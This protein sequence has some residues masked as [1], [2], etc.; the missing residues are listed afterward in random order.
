MLTLKNL[1]K[2]LLTLIKSFK[3]YI[4][5][6]N[7]MKIMCSKHYSQI[8]SSQYKAYNYFYITWLKQNFLFE[9]NAS[10]SILWKHKPLRRG[11]TNRPWMHQVILAE[12]VI[13]YRHA[14]PALCFSSPHPD[15]HET[16]CS[17]LESHLSSTCHTYLLNNQLEDLSVLSCVI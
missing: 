3:T 9:T 13:F 4:N 12:T 11:K 2:Y 1:T 15:A 16:R 10:R 8:D 17:T 14:I 6:Q 7:R 5:T